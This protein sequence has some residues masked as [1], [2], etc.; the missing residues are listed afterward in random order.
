MNLLAEI[1]RRLRR[2]TSSGSY[3]AEIDGL[4]FWAILPVVLWH[5]IQRVSR[6]QPDISDLERSSMLWVPEARVGVMLFFV[7]SGFIISSQFIKNRE[8]GRALDLK[9]YFYRRV[10]R[11]EPPYILLL[12]ATYLLFTLTSYRPENAVAFWRSPESLDASFMAS[13]FYMHGLIFNQMPRLYPG[14]WSLE[15]EVQ[16]YVI[17]PAVFAL[18]FKATTVRSRLVIGGLVLV[19]MFAIER[20]FEHRLGSAGAHRYT[21]IRYFF[22]FWLGALLAEVNAQKCWPRMPTALWDFSAFAGLFV[23]LL[24]GVAEHSDWPITSG[25][26]HTARTRVVLLPLW[27]RDERQRVQESVLRAVDRPHRRCMLLALSEPRSG[28]AGHLAARL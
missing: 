14:G 28:A 27:R 5:G 1:P 18:L 25:Y 10:T 26:L 7:I 19:A 8:K 4:R 17:A 9:S 15:V 13:I 23:Y 20:Y 11:I 24:T 21:L 6:A 2:I 16:F 12:L 22:Y 3:L